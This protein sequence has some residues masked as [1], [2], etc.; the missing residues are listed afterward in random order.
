MKKTVLVAGAVGVIGR[1]VLAHFEDQA[2]ADL[3][4]VS[5]RKP[6]FP[7]R[8]R[9]LSLDLRDRQACRSVLAG[10]PGVTHIVFAAYQERLDLAEQVAPNL[11][12]I[13]NLV[14]TAAELAPGLRHVTLMQGG[15][16]YGCHLGAFPSPAKESDPRHMPPNFYYDQEDFLRVASQ[17]ARWTWTALRPEAVQGIAVGNPM[18]LLMVIAAYALISK[19]LRLPLVFPGTAQ[20]YQ[21]LY[22]VTD[23]R[24]LARATDWAGENPA[25]AGEI[26]NITNGDYFRWSRMWPRIAAFFRMEVAPPLPID[27]RKT[28]ADKAPVWNEIVAR[29]GLRPYAYQD[30]AQWGFGDFIFKTPFDNITST[31]K[32]RRY[33]FADCI[34]SEDMFVELFESLQRDRIIPQD[35]AAAAW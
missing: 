19:K 4:A 28:M 24:I 33:G 21:S 10:C 34:D 2:S 8:A 35:L 6:D 11:E 13:R 26:F 27:L 16:A 17:G 5:R 12:M 18:N 22:Q 15:K 30:I 29:H 23:A 32:A 20:S 14:E 1:A 7:T 25:C 31:I 9:H 3:I